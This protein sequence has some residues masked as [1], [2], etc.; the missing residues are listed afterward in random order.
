MMPSEISLKSKIWSVTVTDHAPYGFKYSLVYIE[1]GVRII[2][3]DN[4]R[5]KGDHRHFNGEETPYLF[6]DVDILME[7]FSRDISLWRGEE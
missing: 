2:G 7:D 4:E 1:H 3:Y 5:G 6:M